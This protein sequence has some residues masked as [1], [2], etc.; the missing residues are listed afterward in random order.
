MNEQSKTEL[1]PPTSMED[2]KKRI[3]LRI[4]A[5]FVELMPEEAWTKIVQGELGAFTTMHAHDYRGNRRSSHL[6][7]II[8][9]ILEE[10]YR[11]MLKIELAKPEY[12]VHL[13]ADGYHNPGEFIKNFIKENMATILTAMLGGVGQNLIE[14]VKVLIQQDTANRY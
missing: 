2:V 12:H 13:G 14:H 3:A 10:R 8:S 4:K 5:S 7:K 9:E 11:E 6:Q 1:A